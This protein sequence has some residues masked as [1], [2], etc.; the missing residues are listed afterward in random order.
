[1]KG[2]LIIRQASIIALT[3]TAFFCLPQER[4]ERHWLDL[5]MIAWF[6]VYF[7]VHSHQAV[8]DSRYFLVMAPPLVYLTL[9]GLNGLRTS[10]RWAT[11][12]WSLWSAALLLMVAASTVS[13]LTSYR[14]IKPEYPSLTRDVVSAA[15]WLKSNDPEIEI[16]TIY[17][18]TW[19]DLSWYLGQNVQP[20]P[21]F[22]D[23]RAMNN[24]LVKYR[25][26]YYV[27]LGSAPIPSYDVAKKVGEVLI[28]RRNRQR[29][30]GAFSRPPNQVPCGP[31]TLWK[32]AMYVSRPRSAQYSWQNISEINFSQ[33]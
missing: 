27:S 12:R 3:I 23:K 32:R 28:Y 1:M 19:V 25:A 21:T 22:K 5:V 29:A 7:D 2:G 17:S 16:R 13:F 15:A 20:M 33:P 9:A 10:S 4:R 26:D 31:Y 11:A 14:E 18:D 30:A 8:K 6:L 24:E